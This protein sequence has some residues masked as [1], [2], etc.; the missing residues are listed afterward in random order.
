MLLINFEK[1]AI[2]IPLPKSGQKYISHILIN[3]YGFVEW[4]NQPDELSDYFHNE[5][6]LVQSLDYYEGKF[7]SITDKGLVRFCLHPSLDP[8]NNSINFLWKTFFKF[9]FI[10]NPYYKFTTAY[11]QSINVKYNTGIYPNEKI[12]N[13]ENMLHCDIK[14]FIKNKND[15][16]NICLYTGFISQKEHLIDNNGFINLQYIGQ[17]SNLDYELIVIL[18]HIGFNQIKHFNMDRCHE[19]EFEIFEGIDDFQKHIPNDC[20]EDINNI[21]SH[22]NN[23]FKFNTVTDKDNINLKPIN[24]IYNNALNTAKYI[25]NTYKKE[26]VINSN[27][28]LANIM[29]THITEQNKLLKEYFKIDS[30]SILIKQHNVLVNKY[31]KSLKKNN[32]LNKNSAFNISCFNDSLH[33][34]KFICNKCRFYSYNNMSFMCHYKTVHN[35]D[36]ELNDADKFI[37]DT[38]NSYSY[39]NLKSIHNMGYTKA[40]YPVNDKPIIIIPEFLSEEICDYIINIGKNKKYNNEHD[41][42]Y[43]N[44]MINSEI[45]ES[46]VSNYTKHLI[47]MHNI[48]KEH[49]DENTKAGF[50]CL[51]TSNEIINMEYNNYKILDNLIKLIRDNTD[52]KNSRLFVTPDEII[53][54]NQEQK[55]SYYGIPIIR[56]Q[57]LIHYQKNEGELPDIDESK[58]TILC[59]LN[60]VDSDNGGRT[61]FPEH[62]ISIT[63]QKGTVVVYSSTFDLL[64]YSEKI[65]AEEKWIMQVFID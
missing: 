7:Y 23:F 58:Y 20:I 45:N 28:I 56:N 47:Q 9:T 3:F 13:N 40:Y 17:T 62:N 63:P 4:E 53:E 65:R 30:D 14:K 39:F 34:K 26:L 50:L 31:F 35:I 43:I 25:F 19:K 10:N 41:P 11:L 32:E 60:D 12:F 6:A 59:Y 1:R 57:S 5:D 21:I 64:H 42:S 48:D 24:Y 33:L 61:I 16:P 51:V 36:I 2:Y 29:Q 44:N 37:D 55:D 15:L 46:S 52:D 27:A 54:K 22:D 18:N 38:Y 49:I 8:N